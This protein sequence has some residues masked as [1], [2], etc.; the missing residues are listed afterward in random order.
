MKR[1]VSHKTLFTGWA[2]PATHPAHGHSIAAAGLEPGQW[3]LVE[4]FG[5][6]EEEMWLGKTLAFG[7]FGQDSCRKRHGGGA[8]KLY[9]TAF[10]RRLH[11]GRL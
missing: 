1:T 7:D 2:L 6:D 11:G 4:A 9:G 8:K 3:V 10:N 5:D